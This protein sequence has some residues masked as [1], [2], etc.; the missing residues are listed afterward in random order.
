MTR[1]ALIGAGGKMGIRLLG[2]LL[3][4]TYELLPVETSDIGIARVQEK[5]LSVLPAST[6]LPQ[7]DLIIFAVPDA[8]MQPITRQ[9]VPL[10]KS[11]AVVV[12]L[13]PAAAA[14]REVTLR[15][16]LHYVVCH[17]CHPPLF[18]E[19]DSDEARK[20]FFG[21]IAA[22]QDIVI[23]LMQGSEEAFAQAEQ[24][25]KQ[26]FAPVVTCHRITVEQ[27]A[28]LE[29]AMAEVVAATAA[30]LMNDALEEAVK[31]G[32]PRA[33]ATSFM[34]GHAQIVMAI[35]F[36]AIGSPYSDAAKVAIRYGQEHIIQPDWRKA[37]A[38]EHLQMVIQ[39]MLHPEG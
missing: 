34:L 38:P 28:I 7:A 21:G 36:G 30:V 13:D 31:A 20:D 33:A 24:L 17:P 23:A 12:M 19:Q 6:A 32:V 22:K 2:N 3:T 18:G 39:Q 27:M 9:L 29:P 37:F 4:T 8:L 25:V 26:A 15:D 35:A 14:A 10:A 11:G 5:G 16:D 1:V